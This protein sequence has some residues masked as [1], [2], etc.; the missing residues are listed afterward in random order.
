METTSPGGT[1]LKIGIVTRPHGLRGAFVVKP[2]NPGAP[3]AFLARI[4]LQLPDAPP[5]C[6][7]VRQ[8]KRSSNG[9]WIAEC[10]DFDLERAQSVRSAVVCAW[11]ADY[12]VLDEKEVWLEELMGATAVWPDGTLRGRVKGVLET[13][14]PY[15]LL[16]LETA[17]GAEVYLPLPREHFV[18]FDAN[19]QILVVSTP[20]PAPDP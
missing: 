18:S 9:H 19:T 6:C 17:S 16:E 5:V 15:P 8:W 7:R 2:F 14:A 3:P 10:P 4:Q 1:L 12:P 13:P 11:A 20:D